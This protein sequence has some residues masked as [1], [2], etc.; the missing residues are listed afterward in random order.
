MNLYRKSDPR[1]FAEFR[2]Y[3]RLFFHPTL[4]SLNQKE[5]KICLIIEQKYL[6]SISGIGSWQRM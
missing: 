2:P 1:L 5:T 4:L 6:E 3:F